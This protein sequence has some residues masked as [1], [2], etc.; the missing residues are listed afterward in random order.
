MEGVWEHCWAAHRRHKI[1]DVGKQPVSLNRGPCCLP[2]A[3]ACSWTWSLRTSG[4]N[5]PSELVRLADSRVHSRP[6]E[7]QPALW[8]NPG[9]SDPQESLRRTGLRT[10][11]PPAWAFKVI[12]V[13]RR[14]YQKSG[15]LTCHWKQVQ[16]RHEPLQMGQP[17]SAQ[18][19]EPGWRLRRHGSY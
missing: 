17:F 19:S 1:Q 13:S 18:R 11:C 5:S 4:I 7:S 16:S 12:L 15:R 10:W 3:R 14:K 6:A 9:D 8:P 2:L